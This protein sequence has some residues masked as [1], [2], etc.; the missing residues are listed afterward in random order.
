MTVEDIRK[1]AIEKRMPKRAVDDM[2]QWLSA[3]YPDGVVEDIA[4]QM[5]LADIDIRAEY[6]EGVRQ[7]LDWS[8]REREKRRS[9]KNK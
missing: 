2:V 5:L 7:F 3:E 4:G 8:K 9:G 6:W 1:Y